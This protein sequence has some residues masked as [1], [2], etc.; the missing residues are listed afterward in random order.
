M[1]TDR[2]LQNKI[3]DFSLVFYKIS[4]LVKCKQCDSEV[5]FEVDREEGLGFKIKVSCKHCKS[6]HVPSSEKIRQICSINIRFTFIMRVLGLG[7]AGCNKFC[8]LMDV[9]DQFVSK[10]TY[11]KYMK[12]VEVV[13]KGVAAHFFKFA[14]E[15]E[16]KENTEE[17]GEEKSNSLTVSGDGTWMK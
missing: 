8:G 15:Q 2:N 3:F 10:N 17:H 6:H 16:K 7:L 12:K 13:T 5:R 14:A 1:N 9:S 11:S 4:Q